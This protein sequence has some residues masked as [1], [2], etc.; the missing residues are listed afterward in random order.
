MTEA[1]CVVESSRVAESPS[2]DSGA[3]SGE[4]YAITK[5]SRNNKQRK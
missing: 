1:N 3:A 4:H 5:K 2:R